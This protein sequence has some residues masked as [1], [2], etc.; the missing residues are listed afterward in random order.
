MYLWNSQNK[1]KT[2]FCVFFNCIITF[3][4]YSPLKVHQPLNQVHL[5]PP[6]PKVRNPIR[7]RFSRSMRKKN[8]K[9]VVCLLSLRFR[10]I[11][12]TR[13]L[14]RWLPARRAL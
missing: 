14:R 7:A 4:V 11:S 9:T 10:V 1:K 2:A 13:V 5:T 6:P 12:E 3:T 8:R